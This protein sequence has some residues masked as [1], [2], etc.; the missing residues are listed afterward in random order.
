MKKYNISFD[1][2]TTFEVNLINACNLKC[3]LC[4]RQSN[5][6][7]NS[8]YYKPIREIKL[9]HL[10]S[11]LDK[12]PNLRRAVLM[13]AVS[14]PT[15]YSKFF[16]FIKYLKSRDIVL[17]ISTNG[18]THNPKWWAELGTL[19]SKD[20][21]V[22]FPIEGPT[23]ELHSKYRVNS[24][25]QKVLENHKALKENSEAITVAQMIQ[26]QY[27]RKYKN[28]VKE[29]AKKEGFDY[30]TWIKC[31]PSNDY[32]KN[33][34]PEKK[35]E[36]FYERYFNDNIFKKE[37][38]IICD[39]Y[40]RK[41]IYLAHNNYVYLCGVHD[42]VKNSPFQK[43]KASLNENLDEIFKKLNKQLNSINND[44]C[45]SNC[46]T[47]CYNVGIYFP[48]YVNNLKTGDQYEINYFSKE[49]TNID[50]QKLKLI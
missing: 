1:D 48:D 33:I 30:C 20:D 45:R 35:I 40:N 10:I 4:L 42:E 44:I 24:S 37:K 11:F 22:R 14:E 34:R 36:K 29:L 7:K 41:E 50:E 2:I 17:R 39:A 28:D 18:S 6:F 23:N 25:L 9:D 43:W 38:C 31:Y 49:L 15:L 16:E 19:L 32:I 5:D 12:L 47:M 3:P 26:F 21:I 46:N 13:G 27:N 8:L